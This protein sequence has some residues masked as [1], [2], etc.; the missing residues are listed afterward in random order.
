MLM[1]ISVTTRPAR[2]GEVE[3][4]DYFFVTQPK[5]RKMVAEHALLEHAE[6]FSH[7]YGTPAHFVNDQLEQGLD[8]LFDIDWQGT[9]QLSTRN[10]DDVVSVFILPPNMA[11]LERRLRARA[12]DSEAVVQER[13][14]KAESEISHWP[15]YDYV[16]VNED[17]EITLARIESILHAERCKRFR[18]TG[19]PAFVEGL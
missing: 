19:L 6:V 1:S 5:F 3:G 4:V 10:R 8:V 9:R 11:E 13:M 18:Q 7:F 15:E 16:L 17:L 14:A 2:P 12:Q